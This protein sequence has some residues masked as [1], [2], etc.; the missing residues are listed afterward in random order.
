MPRIPYVPI[1]QVGLAALVSL[2]VIIAVTRFTDEIARLGSWGYLGV[3]IVQALNSMTV[4]I[5]APGHAYV[6]AVAPTLNPVLAA[7]AAA[8]GAMLGEATSY[9]AGVGGGRLVQHNRLY[10]R[11]TALTEEW[12]GLSIFLFAA[13][14]LPFDIAGL[15]AGSVR[16][17]FWRYLTL[18]FAGKIILLTGIVLAGYFGLPIVQSIPFLD[19]VLS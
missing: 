10:R 16:Y 3:F 2:V 19:G 5:P 7:I 4:F 1:L 12:C 15:W 14:P 11:L 6:F 9:L 13:T 8:L 17:P 18:A